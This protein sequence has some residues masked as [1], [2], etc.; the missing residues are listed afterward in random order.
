MASKHLR[1]ESDPEGGAPSST[2]PAD[3][4]TTGGLQVIEKEQQHDTSMKGAASSVHAE[5]RAD[6]GHAAKRTAAQ[7]R[8]LLDNMSGSDSDS[9]DDDDSSS[10]DEAPAKGGNAAKA[11][12]AAAAPSAAKRTAAAVSATKKATNASS[13]SSATSYLGYLAVG[14]AALAAGFVGYRYLVKRDS[15]AK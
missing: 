6:G 5:D 14:A 10:E 9:D 13:S 12:V 1:F 3:V 11:P 15:A 7:A 2:A 4:T 8:Q